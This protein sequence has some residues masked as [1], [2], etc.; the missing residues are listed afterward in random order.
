MYGR[1]GYGANYQAQQAQGVTRQS[2]QYGGMAAQQPV[3]HDEHG[4]NTGNAGE[5]SSN[6]NTDHF[7]FKV[8]PKPQTNFNDVGH[9]MEVQSS[10]EHLQ[11]KAGRYGNEVVPRESDR[12]SSMSA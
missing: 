8:P 7:Q 5:N 1:Q 12:M 10:N 9:H 2:Q 11:Q 4:R 6:S 3:P